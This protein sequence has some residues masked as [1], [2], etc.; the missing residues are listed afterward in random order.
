MG[1]QMLNGSFGDSG[2]ADGGLHDTG[3]QFVLAGWLDQRE[4]DAVAY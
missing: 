2:P 3:G 4:Q 1:W